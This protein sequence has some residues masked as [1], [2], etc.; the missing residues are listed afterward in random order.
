M[1]TYYYASIIKNEEILSGIWEMELVASDIARAIRPGQFIQLYP[2]DE[3]NILPRPISLASVSEDIITIIYRVVGKGTEQFSHLQK[4]N[5]IRIMGPLGNGFTLPDVTAKSILIGGGLG[6]PPLLE[7]SKRLHGNIEVFL[8]YQDVPFMIE[9]FQQLNLDVHVATQSGKYGFHGNVL[10]MLKKNAPSANYIFACGP[11]PMLQAV[12]EWAKD[13]RIPIQVSMEERMACGI[14]VC[15][16]CGIKIRKP[17]EPDW[18]YM[19][20]CKD[21]PVFNGNE[22]VWNE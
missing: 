16:G 21:G 1:R 10:D 15:L 2:P 14:G 22:V 3:R 13:Q 5:H 17:G 12:S 7:L 4:G 18:K 20:V 9:R 19:R 11:R 8:G 6:I